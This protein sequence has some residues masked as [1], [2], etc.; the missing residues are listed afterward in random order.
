MIRKEDVFKIGVLRKPHGINGEIGMTF[1][2]DVF[3]LASFFPRILSY[4][5]PCYADL[6]P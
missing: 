2:D 4:L 5:N 6:S 3:I 1:T